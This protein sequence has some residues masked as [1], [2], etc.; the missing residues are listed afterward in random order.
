MKA[1]KNSLRLILLFLF[2]IAVG[3]MLIVNPQRLTNIIIIV[4]GIVLMFN[5]II[6][7][8]KF[9][10]DKKKKKTNVLAISTAV[11]YLALGAVLVFA[12]GFVLSVLKAVAVIYG[13]ILVLCGIFKA[14][15][16]FEASKDKAKLSI[17]VL[18]GAL[19]TIAFGILVTLNPIAGLQI[20]TLTYIVLFAAATLDLIAMAFSSM[21]KSK[22]K[23]K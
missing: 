19:L 6:G 12:T 1:L 22:K 7:F 14:Q 2:E 21:K 8:F 17:F 23:K 3:V 10:A 4:F 11:I 20:W 13:L 5:G 18:L 9:L 16:Y 15:C